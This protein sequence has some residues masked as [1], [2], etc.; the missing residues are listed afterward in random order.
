MCHIHV[1][2]CRSWPSVCRWLQRQDVF[3]Q[4]FVV[5][6]EELPWHC[7]DLIDSDDP[8]IPF[9]LLD[10]PAAETCFRNHVNALRAE[11]KRTE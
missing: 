11:Q 1:V 5:T 10:C 2:H 3:D 8:R 6:S 9:D 4:L 7:S